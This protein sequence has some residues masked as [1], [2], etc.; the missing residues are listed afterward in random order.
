MSKT[1]TIILADESDDMLQLM[2]DTISKSPAYKIAGAVNSGDVLLEQILKH[3]PDVVLLSNLLPHLDGIGV[4]KKVREASL[5][6]APAF[7]LTSFL[8]NDSLAIQVRELGVSYFLLKPFSME[9]LVDR[10]SLLTNDSA[11][12]LID[13]IFALPCN[14][15]MKEYYK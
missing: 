5:D 12:K 11:E 2:Q 1:F 4:I 9:S 7:L 3:K 14:A 13:D 10:L 6:K 15:D 8:S